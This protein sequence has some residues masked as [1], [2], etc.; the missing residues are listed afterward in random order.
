MTE[1]VTTDDLF[2]TRDDEG[3]VL[4]VEMESTLLGKTVSLIPMSYGYLKRWGLNMEIPAV[5]WSTEEK[6]RL[7]KDH[8]REPDLSDITIA[9]AENKMGPLT[10]NH[11]VSLVVACSVPTRVRQGPAITALTE[12]L[13]DALSQSDSQ[14]VSLSSTD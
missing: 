10:L 6:L 13:K 11:L 1:Y 4:P 3:A 14:K 12:R 2:I 9:D 8:F 5:Q 7:C